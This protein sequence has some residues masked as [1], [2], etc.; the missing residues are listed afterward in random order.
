MVGIIPKPIKKT[1]KLYELAPYI[2]FGLVL[3]VVLA[4]VAL[5]YIGNK[6]SKTL[7]RIQEQIAQV[8]TQDERAQETQVL[9]DKQKIDD[10]SKLFA[11]HKKTSNFFKSYSL[12]AFATAVSR[13]NTANL[14]LSAESMPVLPTSSTGVGIY[15][16]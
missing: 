1:S 13:S 7:W 5:L 10:F 11:D 9:L 12:R 3:A 8:G 15:L 6:T 16:A 2:V 4:Y 14:Y